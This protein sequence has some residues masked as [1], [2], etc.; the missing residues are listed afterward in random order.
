FQFLKDLGNVHNVLL[1]IGRTYDTG[2]F[3]PATASANSGRGRGKAAAAGGRFGFGRGTGTAT[4]AVSSGGPG[5]SDERPRARAVDPSGL[6]GGD[7]AARR[8]G[9]IMSAIH[10]GG[11]PGPFS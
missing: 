9:V 1:Q 6:D 2:R 10:W 5:S 8:F 11:R 3:F 4:E 7:L